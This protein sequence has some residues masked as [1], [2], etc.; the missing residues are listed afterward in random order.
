MVDGNADQMA[1]FPE[2]NIKGEAPE[3]REPNQKGLTK[4]SADNIG[5]LPLPPEPLIGPKTKFIVKQEWIEHVRKE[6]YLS[7]RG[8]SCSSVKP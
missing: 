5:S 1:G 6:G 7:R 3:D 8:I 2:V 4:E